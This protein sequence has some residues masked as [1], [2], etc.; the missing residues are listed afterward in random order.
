M[1]NASKNPK[2][3]GRPRGFDRDAALQAAMRT[4]WANGYETTSI[5]DLTGAMG[6][7]A[8]AIY[9]AFGNK[10]SLFREAMTLYRGDPE[11]EAQ[12]I[13]NAPSSRKAARMILNWAIDL[14]TSDDTPK[15]CFVA[16]SLATGSEA[17]APLRIEG[18]KIRADV[19]RHLKAR[20]ICDVNA[21][22]L[23]SQTDADALAAMVVCTVQG[24]STLARD[25]ATPAKLRTVADT[26]LKVWP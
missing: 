5:A 20:I 13:R 12:A 3:I 9:S 10:E 8:P 6:V 17:N 22:D 21:G 19:E 24:F 14:F 26:I 2:K 7:N 1:K 23:P 15:G 16:T 11:V 4:F 25:G 18:V